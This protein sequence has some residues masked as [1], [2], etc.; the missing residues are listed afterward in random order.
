MKLIFHTILVE[1]WVDGSLIK[2]VLCHEASEDGCHGNHLKHLFKI[3]FTSTSLQTNAL[4]N[5]RDTI[6]KKYMQVCSLHDWTI[7]HHLLS[8]TK[9]KKENVMKFSW[10][11][12][13]WDIMYEGR[14]RNFICLCKPEIYWWFWNVCHHIFQADIC[15]YCWTFYN[16][17]CIILFQL[18]CQDFTVVAMETLHLLNF[19]IC[20]RCLLQNSDT[21]SKYSK[22]LK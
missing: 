1:K 13:Q 18:Y 3:S 17:S 14:G 21:V 22:I 19:L 12:L 10:T 15:M 7:F 11:L 2:S 8:V 20:F 6:L 5:V 16:D 9:G 4:G